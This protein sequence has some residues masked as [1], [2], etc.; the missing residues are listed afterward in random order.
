[1]INVEINII[2][3]IHVGSGIQYK[4]NSE[5]FFFENENKIVIIDESK[6]LSII[7][8]ENVHIWI[9]YIEGKQD[10]T[11][12]MEYLRKRKPDIIPSDVATRIIPLKGD[13]VPNF[14]NT[15]REQIHS[16]IGLPYIPGSSIKGAIRT[17]LF[18]D[19]LLKKYRGKGI[20][21][22]KLGFYDQRQSRTN[23]NDRP[24]QREIFGIDPN[25]DWLRLLQ[26]GD[27][28]FKAGETHAA[29]SETL[30]ERNWP[31]YEIKEEVRQLIEYLPKGSKSEFALNIPEKH[32]DLI[33]NKRPDLFN[34]MSYSLSISSLFKTV[35]QHSLRLLNSEIDFFEGTDL[36]K[37]K[38]EL[39]AF[40]EE[41]RD[42]AARY[43]DNEC[44][45]RLG[46][47][48]GYRNMTGDWV[49]ELITDDYLYDDIA[50]FSRRTA[51]YNG[52]PLP[53]SRKIM[54]D[55]EFMGYVKLTALN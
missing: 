4:G 50:A 13:K 52:M 15:L 8:I 41:L 7:G 26:V 46:F 28:Y 14:S 5:Y 37:S 48:T 44:L 43:K 9:S 6:I 2:S 31:K 36:P 53:K 21:E 35:H 33:F 16:G 49:K 39:L 32:R 34:P 30:N 38:S 24:L 12:F 20:P 25:S 29:F 10:N 42:E 55:G 3:K 51:R 40:L 27:C 17:A 54:F 18:S 1:M 47:G 45:L 22:A 19:E 11:N 23:F